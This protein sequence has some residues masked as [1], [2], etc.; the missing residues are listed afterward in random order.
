MT[1]QIAQARSEQGMREKS[2]GLRG[3]QG[4]QRVYVSPYE[5]ICQPL[6]HK[7]GHCSQQNQPASVRDTAAEQ[8]EGPTDRA[9]HENVQRTPGQRRPIGAGA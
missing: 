8:S 1:L 9:G 7:T 4:N 2:G 6:P 3:I 5:G